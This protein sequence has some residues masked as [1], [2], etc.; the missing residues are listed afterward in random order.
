[1]LILTWFLTWFLTGTAPVIQAKSASMRSATGYS[2]FKLAQRMDHNGAAVVT[3][4]SQVR[5]LAISSEL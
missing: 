2:K 1:M 4:G 3:S 5:E